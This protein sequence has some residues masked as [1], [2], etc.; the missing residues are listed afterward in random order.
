M[1]KFV[2]SLIT[3]WRKLNLPFV[4][5]KIIVA[6]SG[7]A[8]SVSLTLALHKLR[9]LKKLKI[10]FVIAHFNHKLRAEESDKDE[11]FVE[12]LAENLNFRFICGKPEIEITNQKG[13]LEQI[14]RN[15]RYKFL[16]Q[17]AIELSASYVLTAHTLND[18]AETFLFNLLRGSGIDGL[19]AMKAKKNLQSEE[20]SQ[21][22]NPKS[23]IEL[24]RPILNWAKREETE[25]FCREHNIEFRRD[26]MNEDLKFSRVRIRKQL[27][28]FLQTFNPKIVET[29]AQTSNILS[30]DAEVLAIQN[31]EIVEILSIKRL[32]EMPNV[33]RLNYLRNWLEMRR[34]N[35]RRIEFNHLEAIEK[36]ILSEKS[37][38]I[39]ELPEGGKVT[40]SC[41]KLSFEL[42][43]VEKRRLAN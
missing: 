8:D 15:S 18:Q 4:D 24:V 34:G 26:A 14:A 5:E 7:G 2:R 41:G 29:L 35:L 42:N 19:S 20:K 38:R 3:E 43:I 37:G 40:K 6:V 32:R 27:I 28:P 33:V 1:N 31:D 17:T 10:E 36:L 12:E 30:K 22:P 25:S 11:R 23:Q 16:L 39:V 21:I 13:N 9:E